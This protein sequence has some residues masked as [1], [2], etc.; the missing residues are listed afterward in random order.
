MFD[1]LQ[2]D[3][4]TLLQ[5]VT[6]LSLAFILALPIAYNRDHS[7]LSVGLR[8]FPLVAIASC[9]YMLIAKSVA[10]SPG[11]VEGRA[12]QGMLGGMGFLGGGAILKHKG[13]VYG[14]ANAASIWNTGAI[15]ASIAFQR[16]EIAVLLSILNFSLLKFLSPFSSEGSGTKS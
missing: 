12:L 15:G 9:A 14:L 7:K 2:F 13:N 1:F 16:L 11:E 5:D 4:Q 10:G 6:L 8:T 3:F